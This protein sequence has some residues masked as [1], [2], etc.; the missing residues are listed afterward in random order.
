MYGGHE[1]NKL[2]GDKQEEL[3]VALKFLWLNFER[4]KYVSFTY[5]LPI[6]C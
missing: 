6:C 2:T 3:N 5:C 1:L 4:L